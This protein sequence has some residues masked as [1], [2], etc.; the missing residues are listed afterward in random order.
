MGS[1][2]AQEVIILMIGF[3][4]IVL[5][6][7][8]FPSLMKTLGKGVRNFKDAKNNVQKKPSEGIDDDATR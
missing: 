3:I 1:L 5:I 8:K 2:G 6:F 7:W 4:F